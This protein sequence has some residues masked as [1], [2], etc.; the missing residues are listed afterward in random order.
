VIIEAVPLEEQSPFARAA[1]REREQSIRMNAEA[2]L[3]KGPQPSHKDTI[4]PKK[5]FE[6]DAH[7]IVEEQKEAH[8]KIKTLLL[9]P[10]QY[11]RLMLKSEKNAKDQT[12]SGHDFILLTVIEEPASMQDPPSPPA[13]PQSQPSRVFVSDDRFVQFSEK[14]SHA[15]S[16][17]DLLEEDAFTFDRMMVVINGCCKGRDVFQEGEAR[18]ALIILNDHNDVFLTEDDLI[19][20]L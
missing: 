16:R 4:A 14:L 7:A 17:G 13:L 1:A 20:R 11:K 15:M 2:I 9:T 3:A 19:Y 8:L 10:K 18:A 5:I 12:R 6:E